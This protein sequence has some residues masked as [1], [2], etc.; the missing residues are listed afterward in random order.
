MSFLQSRPQGVIGIHRRVDGFAVHAFT[1]IRIDAQATSECTGIDA[2]AGA[3]TRHTGQG[4][5]APPA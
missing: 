5:Q 3:R 4:P 1:S 2:F